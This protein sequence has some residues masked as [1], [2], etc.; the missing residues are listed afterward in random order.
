MFAH[1]L[2]FIES[3]AFFYDILRAAWSGAIG[4]RTQSVDVSEMGSPIDFGEKGYERIGQCFAL[5]GLVAE[6]VR[7]LAVDA[8]RFREAALVRVFVRAT[9]RL[10]SVLLAEFRAALG[11]VPSVLVSLE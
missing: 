2:V 3:G 5:R 10:K 6:S 1:D 7:L 8:I 11:S 9:R 4:D